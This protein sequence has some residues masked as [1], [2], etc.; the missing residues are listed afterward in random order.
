MSSG[1]FG[2]VNATAMN[3]TGILQ[4]SQIITS[5]PM[6]VSN[7]TA[8]G[9]ISASNVSVCGVDI[10]SALALKAP[11]ANPTFTGDLSVTG[12]IITQS[13]NYTV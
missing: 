2:T 6:S 5:R 1:N 3:V 9:S 4:A 8:T 13:N 12:N 7:L 10:T 11:I